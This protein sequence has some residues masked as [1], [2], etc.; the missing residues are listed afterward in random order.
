MEVT[1][2]LADRIPPMSIVV[3]S[4][5]KLGAEEPGLIVE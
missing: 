4:T 1:K 2:T 3:Y 5:Y